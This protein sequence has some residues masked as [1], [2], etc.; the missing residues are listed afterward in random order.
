MSA[1]SQKQEM[2]GL[3]RS[4][5]REYVNQLLD[6]VAPTIATELTPFAGSSE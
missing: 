3:E 1:K 2:R 5:W 6:S 4:A